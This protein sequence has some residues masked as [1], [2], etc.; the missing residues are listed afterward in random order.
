LDK[1]IEKEAKMRNKSKGTKYENELYDMLVESG[2]RCIRA[3][4]SGTKREAS[5]DLLAGKSHNTFG[6]EVKSTKK[7]YKY[8][9]KEQMNS[10]IVFSHIFKLKPII[11]IRFNREGW[12][13]LKPKDL[14]D[15]GKSFGIKLEMARKKGKRFGQVF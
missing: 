11:A 2:Y 5:V 10:F 14:E 8:I 4:G 9:S 13:F 1:L 7:P 6:I 3:A 15:K 12:F